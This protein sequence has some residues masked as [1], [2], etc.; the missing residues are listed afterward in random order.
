MASVD[1]FL[2][3]FTVLYVCNSM[4]CIDDSWLVD[5]DIYLNIY[6]GTFGVVI[7]RGLRTNKNVFHILF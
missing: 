2:G 5:P 4:V 3:W 6:W 7:G 1:I